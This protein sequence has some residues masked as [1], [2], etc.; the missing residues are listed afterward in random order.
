M[1]SH[2]RST[3]SNLL[4]IT[5]TLGY[6]GIPF[7]AVKMF[8]STCPLCIP[9][10]TIP[11]R[12]KQQPLKMILSKS[13]GARFQMDLVE[14][15]EYNEHKYILRV[16]DHLLKYGYV[17]PLKRRTATEVGDALLR[18]LAT[19]LRPRILQSDNGSEFLGYCVNLMNQ[20]FPWMHIV[21]GRP[22]KPSTQ[23]SIE[24][25]HRAFKAALV[26]WLDK[27]NTANW[28]LGAS[29]VQ[30]EVNRYPMRSRGGLSPH[31][32]Y[33]GH[34][35]MA[36]YSAVLGDAYKTATTEYGL[37]LAKR[38]LLQ[39]KKD[40][41]DLIISQELVQR[42][43][44]IGDDIW[45][46]IT[47]EN[48]D[49]PEEKLFEAFH[50]GVIEAGLNIDDG[51]ELVPDEVDDGPSLV[52]DDG[53]DKVESEDSNND[54]TP[55]EEMVD[56]LDHYEFNL[57][58]W[59]DTLQEYS[60][61]E[62]QPIDVEVENVTNLEMTG[63]QLPLGSEREDVEVENVT[64]LEITG[65]Q[66]CTKTTTQTIGIIEQEVN[67]KKLIV[68]CN[69]VTTTV[70]VGSQEDM[71]SENKLSTTAVD[72]GSQED[73]NSENKLAMLCTT[74]T[75]TIDVDMLEDVDEDVQLLSNDPISGTSEYPIPTVEQDNETYRHGSIITLPKTKDGFMFLISL[76]SDGTPLV[77]EYY[78]CF[79]E[80]VKHDN[81]TMSMAEALGVIKNKGDVVVAI[82]G[83]DLSGK[84]QGDILDMISRKKV[85]DTCNFT[86]ID[87]EA[88][89]FHN[90][91]RVR[92]GKVDNAV[93]IHNL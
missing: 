34:A 64:N 35:P 54:D 11:I 27:K 36:S 63:Q 70:D 40:K 52:E 12:S 20:E 55:T 10:K 45:S 30:C 92:K 23:G 16:V 84:K 3:K 77:E 46:N 42:W 86:F 18:I 88:F 48:D 56:D 32:I 85:G 93:R 7:Q 61:E 38:I 24:V 90:Y 4:C 22:R 1:I 59:D 91:R 8:F 14:M 89:N 28:I 19:S 57:D 75:A 78:L 82:D 50:A 65:E 41:P 66:E 58:V 6:Y 25:S 33:Y 39:V 60:D 62:E 72:V 44:T 47:E 49:D 21:R 43:I 79:Q 69:T 74:A 13:A 73:M 67:S 29:V 31:T 9:N 53:D 68:E 51:M 81:N 37:R 87:K 71:D 17:H 76:P 83:V 5:N 2:A 15:L 26:K 80:Y